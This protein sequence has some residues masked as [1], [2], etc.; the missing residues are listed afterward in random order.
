MRRLREWTLRAVPTEPGDLEAHDCLVYGSRSMPTV[1]DWRFTRGEKTWHVN[2]KHRFQANNANA[3]LVAALDGLGIAFI[4]EDLARE[5]LRSG[6]L[7]EVLP[8]YAAAS[9]PIH[10][11]YHRDRMQ[12]PKLKSFIS[13]VMATLGR[14]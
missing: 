13:I 3:L 14:L 7:A 12:T 2:V 11:I 5:G 8:D 1:N 4:A 6:R 10:I 9:R